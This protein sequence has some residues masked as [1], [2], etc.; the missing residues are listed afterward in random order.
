MEQQRKLKRR[1]LIFFLNVYDMDTGNLIGHVVDITSEGVMLVSENKI[2]ADKDFNLRVRIPGENGESKF[3]EFTARSLWSKN[4]V[5]PIFYDTG[6]K[7]IKVSI[8]D[9]LTIA[10]TIKE[11]G[12]SD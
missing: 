9:T 7:F 5:N 10:E 11:F 12:F 8:R 4:D 2:P 6:F 1:H 3:L